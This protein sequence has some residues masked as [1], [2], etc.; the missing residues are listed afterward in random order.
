MPFYPAEID[1]CPAFGWQVS[2]AANVQIKTLSNRH[3]KRNRQGDLM[4]H[5]FSLPFLNIPSDEYLRYI[6]SAYMA[7]GGPSD[8]FLA[9]DYG[10]NEGSGESL[11]L[12]PAGATPVQLV[13]TYSFEGLASYTRRITKPVANS[14]IVYEAG[15]PKAGTVSATTGLFTPDSAW[16]EGAELTAD[17]GFR[18]PVRFDEVV[19]PLTIDSRSGDGYRMNGTVTLREVF[20][21]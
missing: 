18:V 7:L 14:V 12:A 8:S 9:N 19:L 16:S 4:Q 2:I 6:K 11:G 3:E 21:E 5:I 17:Y 1:T 10:D 15:T 13:K 20:G